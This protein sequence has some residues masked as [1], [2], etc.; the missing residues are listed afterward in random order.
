MENTIILENPKTYTEKSKEKLISCIFSNRGEVTEYSCAESLYILYKDEFIYYNVW[1]KHV[2][3]NWITIK[4]GNELR[5]RIPVLKLF[6]DEEMIEI[7]TTIRF[8]E[9][10]LSILEENEEENTDKIVIVK[11][12]IKKLDLKR[13][14]L[15]NA[16]HQLDK[17]GFKNNIIIECKDLF[18]DTNNVIASYLHTK[19]NKKDI[20]CV[21]D[22]ENKCKSTLELFVQY[23][24]TKD[25]EYKDEIISLT[26]EELIYKFNAFTDK[27]NINDKANHTIVRQLNGLNINGIKTSV[28][29]H[30]Q[31]KDIKKT[32]FNKKE[33]KSYLCI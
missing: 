17:T 28:R 29:Y 10:D 5:K 30:N 20:D 18:L 6:I 33:I 13:E 14:Y 27:Y 24:I 11:N 23:L 3:I 25:K 26:N 19:I 32:E 21:M 2:D 31:K 12:N 16:K 22:T 1:Y 15:I 9:K 7:R 8:Y 4:N